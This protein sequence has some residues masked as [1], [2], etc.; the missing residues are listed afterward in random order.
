[1]LMIIGKAGRESTMK[2]PDVLKHG[3]PASREA[4]GL[5]GIPTG[6]QRQHMGL[7]CRG[8]EC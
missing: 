1:M 8:L 2:H 3:A 7:F 4:L 5:I 6:S